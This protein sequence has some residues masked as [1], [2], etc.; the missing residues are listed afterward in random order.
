MH[1][2]PEYLPFILGS[3]G[4]F[5][6]VEISLGLYYLEG[7]PKD[8]KWALIGHAISML[9]GLLIMVST[10]YTGDFTH[11]VTSQFGMLILCWVISIC[12]LMKLIKR[13]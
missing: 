4:L 9:C 1:L 13:N 3:I 8:K 6:L 11:N 12:F 5:T 10:Y 7:Q 2:E